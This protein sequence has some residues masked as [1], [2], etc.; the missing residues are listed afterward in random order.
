LTTFSFEGDFE[1]LRAVSVN[2]R[3][4]LGGFAEIAFFAGAKKTIFGMAEPPSFSAKRG[5][6]RSDFGRAGK[7]ESRPPGTELGRKLAENGA[8]LKISRRTGR[9]K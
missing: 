2:V 1:K 5:G 6:K 3:R 8:I 4:G 7:S 9:V